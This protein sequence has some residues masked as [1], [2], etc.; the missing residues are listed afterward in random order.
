MQT[1][2]LTWVDSSTKLKTRVDK[3][4]AENPTWNDKFLF[5][6]SREFLASET[7]GVSVAIYAV[8]CLRDHLIGTVRLILSNIFSSGDD[9]GTPSFSAFQIRRPSGRFHGVINI[10]AM[11]IEGSEFPMLNLSPAIGLRDLMGENVRLGI[12]SKRHENQRKLKSKDIDEYS[13]D[14][15]EE[16]VSEAVDFSDGTESSTSSSSTAST[17]L[18]DWNGVRELAGSKGLKS[19]GLF[20]G[21][22]TQRRIHLTPSNPNLSLGV[23]DEER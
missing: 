16:S 23:R 6:V 22:L 12:K 1:Y 21:L 19:P 11:V 14:S 15:C 9:V 7:S 2:A 8:G 20:C 18:K 4:G 10:A 3:I 5:R 13:S 17:A